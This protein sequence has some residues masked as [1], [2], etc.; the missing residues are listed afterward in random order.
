[1][2]RLS[3]MIRVMDSARRN[4]EFFGIVVTVPGSELPELIINHPAS[5]LYKSEYYKEAYNDDCEKSGTGIKVI[6]YKSAGNLKDFDLFY[7]NIVNG[8]LGGNK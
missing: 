5:L 2:S 7:K 4:Y 8:L 1:M 3:R 6:G